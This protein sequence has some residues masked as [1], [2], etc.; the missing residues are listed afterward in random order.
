MRILKLEQGS[1]EWIEARAGVITGT[2]LK[3]ALGKTSKD[4]IYELIAETVAPEADSYVTEAMERGTELENEAIQRYELETGTITEEVGF[5][6]HDTH[7]WLG[8]SPDRLIKEKG[9]YKKAVEVK[10]PA[11]KTHLKY[12]AEDK[13]P[14]EYWYQVL[15]YFIVCDTLIELDFVSYDPRVTIENLQFKIITVTRKELQE[16]IE[17]AEKDLLSFR[18]KWVEINN[19]L[20]F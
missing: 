19:T 18:E 5:C 12:I 2:S 14:S 10:C 9:K 1:P 11:T 4:Y 7:D 6:L 15:Q 8:L 17:T 3:Q 13:I 20:T 16:D